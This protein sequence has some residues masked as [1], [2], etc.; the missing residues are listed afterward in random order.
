MNEDQVE[1]SLKGMDDLDFRGWNNADWN[2]VFAVH[3]NDDV[4]VDWKGQVPTRGIERH[5][6]AMKSYRRRAGATRTGAPAASRGQVRL[7]S[8]RGRRR[9]LTPTRSDS[10]LASGR[11]S[12]AS[13]KTVAKRSPWRSGATAPSL[14]STSGLRRR[15]PRLGGSVANARERGRPCGRAASSVGDRHGLRTRLTEDEW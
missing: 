12:S 4:L 14:R 5:I 7:A 15:F 8:A 6:E 10:G 11:A 3:H 13:S 2:G 9:R 1:A